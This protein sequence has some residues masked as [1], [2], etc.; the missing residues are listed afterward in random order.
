MHRA[1]YRRIN[2]LS[3]ALVEKVTQQFLAWVNA[4]IRNQPF[5]HGADH[6]RGRGLAVGLVVIGSE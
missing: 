1:E 3:F 6:P 2:I 4:N 5:R